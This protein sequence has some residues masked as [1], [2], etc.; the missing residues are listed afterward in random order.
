M[1]NPANPIPNESDEPER[2]HRPRVLK[3]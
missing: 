1:A 3:G 2:E